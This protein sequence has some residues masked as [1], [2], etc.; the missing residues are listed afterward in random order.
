M[1]LCSEGGG[2]VLAFPKPIAELERLLQLFA[3]VR[4]KRWDDRAAMIAPGWIDGL[5]GYVSGDGVV[6]LI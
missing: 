2:K 1:V 6:L 3:G 5:Q 4:R